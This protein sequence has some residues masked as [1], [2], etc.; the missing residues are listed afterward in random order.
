MMGVL[1]F[2]CAL[3]AFAMSA[4]CGGGASFIIIPILGLLLPAAQVPLTLS[5]GT[6]ASSISRMIVFRRYIRWSIVKIFLPAAVPAVWLGAWLLTYINPLYL[7]LI[8]ALFLLANLP[9]IFRK[10][11]VTVKEKK[12]NRIQV[13]LIGF[14]TGFVSGLTGAVGLLFN[15]FYLTYGLSKE[16][17]VA[18]RAANEL[19]LHLVKIVLYASFG[20]FS[21]K[22]GMYGVV[23]IMAAFL[24]AWITGKFL[25]RIS[26]HFFRKTG[27]I[28]MVLAGML[29]LAG[30]VKT[31]TRTNHFSLVA[32]GSEATIEWSGNHYAVE[33]KWGE[34]LEIEK[35]IALEDVPPAQREVFYTYA[36]NAESMTIEKIFTPASKESRYEL[37]LQNNGKWRKQ[38]IVFD[39]KDRQVNAQ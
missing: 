7:Q 15:R 8:I 25:H 39:S 4:V 33:F 23:I 16:E 35:V 10:Q 11:A 27:Y 20:L 30:S 21:A 36:A 38:D 34:G 1:L 17:I 29:M 19:L 24:S 22:A 13:M 26:D 5:I 28:S 14:F 37:Y 31:L 3:I 6:G 18:T 12:Q 32:N 2:L 9:M